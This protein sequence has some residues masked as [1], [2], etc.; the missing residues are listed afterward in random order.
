MNGGSAFDV[1]TRGMSDGVSDL[2]TGTRGV[3]G[4]APQQKMVDLRRQTDAEY[5][6]LVKILGAYVLVD[7]SPTRYAD[8]VNTLNEDINYYEKTVFAGGATAGRV[9]SNRN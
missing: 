1:A 6:D 3:S 4:A 8:L 9:T 5:R 2:E 7:A